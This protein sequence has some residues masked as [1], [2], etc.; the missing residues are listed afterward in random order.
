MALGERLS[1]GD[2][3]GPGLFQPLADGDIDGVSL[4]A[5]S[6]VADIF[7]ES[8]LAAVGDLPAVVAGEDLDVVVLVLLA[9]LDALFAGGGGPLVVVGDGSGGLALVEAGD[10]A[11]DVGV[12]QGQPLCAAESLDHGVELGAR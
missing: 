6:V 10:A 8:F 7:G 12:L 1:F 2:E 5:Q 3:D 4:A 9:Q 11:L